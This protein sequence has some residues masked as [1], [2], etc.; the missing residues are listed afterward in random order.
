MRINT[1]FF[2]L[3]S[4]V[5]KKENNE[6]IVSRPGERECATSK[7]SGEKKSG[8]TEIYQPLA[9][10]F[11]STQLINLLRNTISLSLNLNK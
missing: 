3:E 5:S 2:A 9:I 8:D 10:L 7:L 4:R 11:L 1:V 6:I